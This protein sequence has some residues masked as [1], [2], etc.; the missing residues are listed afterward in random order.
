M[1]TVPT[2]ITDEELSSL[3]AGLERTPLALA[4]SGGA[5][6]MALMHLVARWAAREEVRAAYRTWW[7][8]NSG[9]LHP[10]QPGLRAWRAPE[11]ILP[12]EALPHVVVLTVDHG[13]RA[14]AADEAALVARAAEALGLPCRVLRWEG[15]KP[16]T[17]IQAAA[18]EARR[19]LFVE[20]LDAERAKLSALMQEHGVRWR[21]GA[22]TLV[23]AHH[24][25]DQA[26]T[27]LMR[28][29]RG[30]GLDGLVAMRP[31]DKVTRQATTANPVELSVP[32]A[33]PLLGVSKARLVATLQ[34][35]GAC[36]IDDPSNEDERFERVRI[37]TALRQ[38]EPLGFN[39]ERIA[40][41]ARRLADAEA[42]LRYFVE[43]VVKPAHI[44]YPQW[45]YG[46]VEVGGPLF[47][48]AYLGVRTLRQLILVYG[49]ASRVPELAQLEA[50]FPMVTTPELRFAQ[51]RLTLGGCVIEVRSGRRGAT[52]RVY[53]EGRGEGLP[54]VPFEPGQRVYWD[55]RRFMIAAKA[56][57]T[58][59]VVRALGMKGWADLKR[60]VKGLGDL[61]WPAAAVATVPVIESGGEIIAYP[62]ID[63]AVR[64][65]PDDKLQ[66]KE[67]WAEYASRLRGADYH[68]TL[69][70]R[71]W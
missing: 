20:A 67:R 38:L 48:G 63:R 35:Y 23:M 58:G 26:E 49:G 2:A 8:I 4:V 5:D 57:S 18:R 55:G 69:N 44:M 29:A 22:R 50:L 64:S 46:E 54:I 1:S 42:S 11:E 9:P 70:M 30:S 65:L 62:V 41:S 12:I 17:G 36:W 16:A 47:A 45:L 33:R 21:R 25:E 7:K 15:E 39:A 59:G 32:L 51:K 6:S 43:E 52:V 66:I 28:L 27:L 13:L 19:V 56:N 37:R 40:L 68:V 14:G 31:R 34:A 24:Q 61:G 10:G 71:P 53:R 60:A 3:F